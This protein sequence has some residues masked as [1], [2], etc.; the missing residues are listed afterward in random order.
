MGLEPSVSISFNGIFILVSKQ[1]ID[2]S[3]KSHSRIDDLSLQTE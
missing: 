1:A 3:T 2:F